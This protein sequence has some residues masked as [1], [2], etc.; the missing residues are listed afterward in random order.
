MEN[1]EYIGI[2]RLYKYPKL[3][4]LESFTRDFHPDI[5]KTFNRELEIKIRKV[6]FL[7]ILHLSIAAALGILFFYL[8]FHYY[9][10]IFPLSVSFSVI[11]VGI[12]I[13]SSKAIEIKARYFKFFKPFFLKHFSKHISSSNSF[14]LIMKKKKFLLFIER[15]V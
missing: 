4:L 9:E 6:Y 15:T 5:I 14:H 12:F 11:F 2:F 7:Y 3:E 8:G 1:S 13:Y 10:S